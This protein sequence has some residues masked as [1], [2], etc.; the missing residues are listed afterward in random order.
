MKK[1]SPAGSGHIALFGTSE[2]GGGMVRCGLCPHRCRLA[3]GE[4]GLCRVRR[5]RAGTLVADTYRRPVAEHADPIETMPLGWFMPGSSVYRVGTFGCNL[6]CEFCME[7]QL[8]RSSYPAGYEGSEVPPEDIVE[9]A[10]RFGCDAV[11]YAM[12]EPTIFIEYVME[13][14]ERARRA[15]LKNILVS[16]GYILSRPRQMLYPLMD[17][18]S[19]GVKGFSEEFY[20]SVCGGHLQPVLDSCE[21]C[22]KNGIH[23]EVSSLLI[24]RY[25]DSGKMI[26][27]FLDWVSGKLGRD[28]PVHFVAYHPAGGFTAPPTTADSVMSAANAATLR[29]FTRVR[30]ITEMP[31]SAC[32]ALARGPRQ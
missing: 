4:L 17:A 32:P 18:A 15:G 5:N 31:E 11:A 1:G 6:A 9:N 8:S 26:G 2:E 27:G 16:N 22:H 21:Y 19:I 12:N 3:P 10:K 28:T 30:A 13:I 7:D 14:A 20:S 29:G 25:N 24:P 23:L